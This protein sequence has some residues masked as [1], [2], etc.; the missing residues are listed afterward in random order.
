MIDVREMPTAIMR[1]EVPWS[2]LLV[3]E[4]RTALS[5]STATPNRLVV[6]RKGRPGIE[7]A[8]PL[9]FQLHSFNGTPQVRSSAVRV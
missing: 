9:A 5:S 3:M 4:P 7:E 2:D 8:T 1:W 6:H